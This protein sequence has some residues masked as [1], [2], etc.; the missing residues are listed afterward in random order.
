MEFPLADFESYLSTTMNLGFDRGKAYKDFREGTT[1]T[2]LQEG[3]K[4]NIGKLRVTDSPLR[5]RELDIY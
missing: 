5:P 3:V 2:R 4:F 1:L